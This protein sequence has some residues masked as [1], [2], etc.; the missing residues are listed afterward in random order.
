MQLFKYTNLLAKLFFTQQVRIR[1]YRK[2]AAMTRHGINVAD[3]VSYIKERY[4]KQRNLLS[5]VL[6]EVSARINSGD[7]IHEALRGFI[8]AEEAS[9]ST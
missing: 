5:P 3:A 9:R 7:N 4:A 8:P 6:T 1:V 2:L